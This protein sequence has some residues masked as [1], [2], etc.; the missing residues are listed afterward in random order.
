MDNFRDNKQ[1]SVYVNELLKWNKKINLIG[2][3]T[4][5]DVWSNHIADSL[6]LLPYLQNETLDTIIDIGSGGGL[7]AIPLSI[8]L[9]DKHFIL[10]EVN[11]KK[12]AFLEWVINLLGINAQVEN[13]LPSTVFHDEAI[14]TSRAFAT[15]D[16]IIKWQKQHA[17]NTKKF[18]L[19]KGT[20]ENTV[21]ELNEV[22]LNAK[23]ISL[24]KGTI[25][26]WG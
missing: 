22:G 7:P 21:A 1:I 24:N 26:C 20:Y 6:E 16:N 9:P 4:V 14:I 5:N 15:I 10:C 13:I 11:K 23:V 2:R 17:P 19:L 8:Y 12:I 3:Q 18:C 25:V